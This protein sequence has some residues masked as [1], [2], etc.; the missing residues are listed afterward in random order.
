MMVYQY[1]PRRRSQ[2]GVCHSIDTADSVEIE[3]TDDIGFRCQFVGKLFITVVQKY[4]LAAGHP[5]QEIGKSIGNN[6]SRIL[7]LRIKK[8]PQPQRRAYC[9]SVGSH[10]GN[11]NY[12]IRTFQPLGK[13]GLF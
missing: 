9:I 3:A 7:V 5:F 11:N 12:F 1:L 4:I 8:M 10:M 6:D 2:H 13:S